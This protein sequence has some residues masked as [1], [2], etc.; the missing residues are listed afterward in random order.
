MWWKH[1]QKKIKIWQVFQKN[2]NIVTK[3]SLLIWISHTLGKFCSSQ[4]K[5][6]DEFIPNLKAGIKPQMWGLKLSLVS[7]G[8]Q[9]NLLNCLLYNL[10]SFEDKKPRVDTIIYK[11]NTQTFHWAITWSH[12]FETLNLLVYLNCKILEMPTLASEKSL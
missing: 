12:L 2:E 6:S 5:L 11:W 7:K 1:F 4:K 10:G 3:Y 9:I 8:N